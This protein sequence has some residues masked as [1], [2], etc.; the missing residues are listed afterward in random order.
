MLFTSRGVLA[1]AKPSLLATAKLTARHFSSTANCNIRQGMRRAAEN[2]PESKHEC[3]GLME[4]FT[5]NSIHPKGYGNEVCG[6]AIELLRLISIAE[7]CAFIR[8]TIDK[9]VKYRMTQ[10]KAEER[11]EERKAFIQQAEQGKLLKKLKMT[12]AEYIAFQR[13]REK[14]NKLVHPDMS[15]DNVVEC[16]REWQSTQT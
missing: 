2:D 16:I 10:I 3:C 4:F 15:F 6:Q 12:E 7:A 1:A 13:E 8:T 14:R 11:T 5:K 9:Q